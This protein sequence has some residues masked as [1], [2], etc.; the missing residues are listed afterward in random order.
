MAAALSPYGFDRVS[1]NEPADLY[2]INTCTVTHRADSDCRYLIRRAVRANPDARIVVAG[3]FVDNDPEKVA[4]MEPVD[5]IIPNN[6]KDAI[7]EILSEKFP[8]LFNAPP[9]KNCSDKVVEFHRHNRAWIKVSDGCNQTCSFCILPRVRG[10][11]ANRP[12]QEI[13]DEI[14]GL[15]AHDYEEVVLTGINIGY[16]R[17]RAAARSLDDLADLCDLIM[18]ETDLGRIR[19]SSIEPQTVTDK[20]LATLADSGGRICRHWHIPMQSGSSRVLRQMR[21]PYDRDTYMRQVEKARAA[22][23][24]T[25]IGA[26][27]IVGFPGET[28]DD[29]NY[30][31]ELAQSGLIDYLHVFSYSDRPQ[32]DAADRTE[33]INPELI[34][35]RNVTLKKISDSLKLQANQRQVGETLEVISEHRSSTDGHLWGVSDNYIRALMPES[36]ESSKQ[37][38]RFSVQ[39]ADIKGVYGEIVPRSGTPH[40]N[41]IALL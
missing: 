8:D 22:V 28:E 38:V 18:R 26:D 20:L 12:S 13:I 5:V 34:K 31:V 35:A 2:I 19:I 21:R 16:Y 14:N 36:F 7:S 37:I 17:D 30:S 1:K 3:C 32:T 41:S 39:S 27:I 24:N 9:D 11:L 40:L 10:R 25:I 29:F 15:V 23:P 33:K 6:Q 4:G